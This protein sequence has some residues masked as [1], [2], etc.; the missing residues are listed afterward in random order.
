MNNHISE[1]VLCW[2][3]I[4]RLMH[5]PVKPGPRGPC[6]TWALGYL[7]GRHRGQGVQLKMD[8]T[9]SWAGPGVHSM[10]S[11]WWGMGHNCAGTLGVARTAYGREQNQV[12]CVVGTC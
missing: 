10:P 8:K 4:G 5:R 12:W 1:F 7:E 11:T 2:L 6:Q 9:G 3:G